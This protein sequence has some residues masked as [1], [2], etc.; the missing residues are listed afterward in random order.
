MGA[1]SVQRGTGIYIEQLKLGHLL[2]FSWSSMSLRCSLLPLGPQPLTLWE[3]RESVLQDRRPGANVA[4]QDG[5]P[6]AAS[7]AV[8]GWREE[9]AG[10]SGWPCRWFPLYPAGFWACDFAFRECV[11]GDLSR[12]QIFSCGV[13]PPFNPS[14]AAFHQAPESLQVEPALPGPPASPA[15]RSALWQLLP[16]C[17]SA[18]PPPASSALPHHTLWKP[19]RNS[20]LGAPPPGFY[21][22]YLPSRRCF[23]Q[24]WVAAR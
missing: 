13:G 2:P 15:S 18:Q 9:R 21:R 10:H 8:E 24:H 17:F 11:V 20:R 4:Q 23:W 19:S 3:V 6:A 5:K 14:M 16:V 12:A 1:S 7:R 22:P